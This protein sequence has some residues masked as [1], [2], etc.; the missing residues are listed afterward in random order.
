MVK[1]IRVAVLYDNILF[2]N[3]PQK[4]KNIFSAVRFCCRKVIQN[5]REVFK[6]VYIQTRAK[7]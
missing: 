6:L 2:E 7:K 5:F 3:E 4:K 1:A